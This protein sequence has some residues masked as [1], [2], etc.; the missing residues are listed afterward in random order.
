MP[1]KVC[2]ATYLKL[3]AKILRDGEV[4]AIAPEPEPARFSA[5]RCGLTCAKAFRSSPP[6][7][8]IGNPSSMSFYV[9]ARRHQYAYLKAQGVGIWDEWA[10]QNGISDVYGKQWRACK[11]RTGMSSTRFPVSWRKSSAILFPAFDRLRLNPADLPQMAL[12][13]CLP[14]QFYVAEGT[15]GKKGFHAA[16]PAFGDVFLGVPFTLQAMRF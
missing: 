13:P 16:L 1:L 2:D 15:D 8:C 3:L 9:F 12:A 14:V 5:I 6:R 4:K 10:D 11:P 7:S